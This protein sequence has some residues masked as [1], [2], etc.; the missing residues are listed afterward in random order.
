MFENNVINEF[1][2][3][4]LSRVAAADKMF[5]NRE[6]VQ[7]AYEI[8]DKSYQ[9]ILTIL[10]KTGQQDLL[11]TMTSAREN[12][13]FWTLKAVYIQ[14]FLDIYKIFLQND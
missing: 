3:Y 7:K 6:E 2:H 9:D 12:Y 11:T 13:T 4:I 5:K 10:S 1:S 8:Y 14:A